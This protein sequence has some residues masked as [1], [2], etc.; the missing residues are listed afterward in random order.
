MMEHTNVREKECIHTCVTGSPCC[1]V[2][3]KNYWG[4]NNNKN[5][6]IK[7]IFNYVI[8]LLSSVP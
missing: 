3:K 8:P 6:Y 1:T 5:I 2:E 7:E 4:N